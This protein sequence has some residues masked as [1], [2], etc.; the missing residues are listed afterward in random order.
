M[1]RKVTDEKTGPGVGCSIA[2]AGLCALRRADRFRRRESNYHA[3]IEA[4]MAM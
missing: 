4:G 2:M 1:L 3:L